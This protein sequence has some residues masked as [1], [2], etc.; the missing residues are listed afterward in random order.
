MHR[1]GETPGQR[2]RDARPLVT[3][4]KKVEEC[5]AGARRLGKHLRDARPLVKPRQQVQG[6]STYCRLGNAGNK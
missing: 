4:S 3:K 6:A 5:T 1:G 2:L